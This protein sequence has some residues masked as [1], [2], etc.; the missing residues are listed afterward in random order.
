MV[1][2]LH[3]SAAPQVLLRLRLISI[4]EERI[5][6]TMLILQAW[7]VEIPTPPWRWSWREREEG[8]GTESGVKIEGLCFLS[9]WEETGCSKVGNAR[10]LLISGY[11]FEILSTLLSV[12]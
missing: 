3:T 11:T 12:V 6:G 4:E 1:C 2:Y 10:L 8:S 5:I 9:L 7:K